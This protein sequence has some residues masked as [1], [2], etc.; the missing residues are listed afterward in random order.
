MAMA[1]DPI[2]TAGPIPMGPMAPWDRNAPCSRLVVASNPR[3]LEI[4]G[5]HNDGGYNVNGNKKP[6]YGDLSTKAMQ[7]DFRPLDLDRHEKDRNTQGFPS[8]SKS[9]LEAMQQSQTQVSPQ[10]YC[11]HGIQISLCMM[12]QIIMIV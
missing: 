12:Y 6:F 11:E 5:S 7:M 4:E 2:F 3:K 10:H 1:K 9:A 8:T